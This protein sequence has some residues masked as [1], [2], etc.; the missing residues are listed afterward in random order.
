MFFVYIFSRNIECE[1]S[2]ANRTHHY[3]GTATSIWADRA[4][5]K[6]QAL[7]PRPCLNLFCFSRRATV[8][9]ACSRAFLLEFFTDDRPLRF[10]AN[11]YPHIYIKS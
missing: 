2:R 7:H 11:S 1:N 5:E 3:R 4:G 6:D 9:G 10:L 8:T